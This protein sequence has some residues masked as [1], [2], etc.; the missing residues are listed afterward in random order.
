MRLFFGPWSRLAWILVAIIVG[1]GA[2][3][4]THTSSA[5]TNQGGFTYAGITC[6]TGKGI[7]ACIQTDGSGYGIGISTRVVAVQNQN[8]RIVY[9][10]QQP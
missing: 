7:I 5:S 1:A 8:R 6:T 2:A 9:V 10:H 3:V 4:L